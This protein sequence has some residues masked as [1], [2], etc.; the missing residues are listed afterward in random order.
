MLNKN[1]Y[2]FLLLLF[3]KKINYD[4]NK[5]TFSVIKLI[6]NLNHFMNLFN[7]LD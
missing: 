1:F 4:K 5:I 3:I 6:Q 2:G 7:N